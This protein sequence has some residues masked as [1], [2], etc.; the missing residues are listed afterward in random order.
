MKVICINDTTDFDSELPVDV[1]FGN[2]YTVIDQE[3]SDGIL[4]YHLAEMIH[5]DSYSSDA[6]AP[7]SE[8]DEVQLAKKMVELV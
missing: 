6:F 7:L 3:K 8:I 2:I 1:V 4:W 5:S